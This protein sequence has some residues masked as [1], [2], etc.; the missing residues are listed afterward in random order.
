MKDP[1]RQ[2]RQAALYDYLLSRGNNWTSMEQ[3]TDSISLYPAFFT[4]NYHDST[5]RRL[6]SKDIWEINHSDTFFKVIVSDDSGKGIKIG[7]EEETYRFV[8]R[9]LKEVFKKLSHNRKL[10]RKCKRDQQID[11]EG[12]I[13]E[14][15]LSKEDAEQTD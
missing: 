12:R 9:E 11:L 1:Y 15:F 2:E 8:G 10:I 14:A 7:T 13:A 4:S 5:A 6:L 3:V